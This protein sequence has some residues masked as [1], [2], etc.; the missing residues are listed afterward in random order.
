LAASAC[1]DAPSMIN[2]LSPRPLGPIRSRV[3]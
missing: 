3:A 1:C 2:L